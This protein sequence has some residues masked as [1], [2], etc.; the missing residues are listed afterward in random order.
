MSNTLE[1]SLLAG[2]RHSSDISI[3]Q[4]D[5]DINEAH[6]QRIDYEGLHDKID[7]PFAFYNT[8]FNHLSELHGMDMMNNKEMDFSDFEAIQQHL[9]EEGNKEEYKKLQAE[10]R[11]NRQKLEHIKIDPQFKAE[12]FAKDI[13][14]ETEENHALLPMDILYKFK[15]R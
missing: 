9:Q 10:N 13:R 14:A 8:Q 15:K 4:F 3:R 12:I 1:L 6:V 5:E 7:D 2:Y 11:I